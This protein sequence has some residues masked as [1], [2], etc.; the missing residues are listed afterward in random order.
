MNTLS[1]IYDLLTVA[2]SHQEE[3]QNS[4]CSLLLYC[5]VGT[6]VTIIK[7]LVTGILPWNVYLT[8]ESLYLLGMSIGFLLSIIP[9]LGLVAKVLRDAKYSDLFR[10]T[11]VNVAKEIIEKRLVNVSTNPSPVSDNDTSLTNSDTTQ[12]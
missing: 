9:V 2:V 10:S 7:G 3:L 4:A 1:L 12:E 5:I 11:V 8:V 6:I